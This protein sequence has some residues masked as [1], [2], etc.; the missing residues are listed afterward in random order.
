MPRWDQIGRYR[1]PGVFAATGGED[2]ELLCAL[3]EAAFAAS[4]VPLTRIGEIEAGPAGVRF[5]GEG[6]TP[7]LIGYDHLAREPA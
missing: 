3:D 1:S 5:R 6:A 4:P 7:D 2:Y